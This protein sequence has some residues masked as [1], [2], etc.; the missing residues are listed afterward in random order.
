MQSRQALLGVT[1]GARAW[2][3]MWASD[4]SETEARASAGTHANP[5]AWQ[6][7]HVA[8]TQDFIY[9]LFTG[10]PGVVPESLHKTCGNACPEPTA[11]TTFPS[12]PEL[13]A[14]LEKTQANIVGLIESS[15]E[16]ELDRPPLQPHP[17]FPS[18]GQAIHTIATNEAFHT[19]Q[20]GVLRKAL[21]KKRIA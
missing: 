17:F 21:G 20:V 8:C 16:S 3:K 15:S 5:L 1:N 2:L 9:S 18:L 4:F 13:W 6:L 19:G 12:S 11:A 14:L 7:G 10:K